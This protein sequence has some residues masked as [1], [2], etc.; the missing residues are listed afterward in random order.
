VAGEYLPHANWVPRTHAPIVPRDR[1]LSRVV[2]L[3][4][5]PDQS[6]ITLVGPPGAGKTTLALM[7]A[8]A[9]DHAFRDGVSF[10][11]L[12]ATRDPRLVAQAVATSIG[13]ADASG[14][15]LLETLVRVL[16]PR[17][18]LLILDNFEQV[19]PAAAT[20]R[21]L[22]ER[23]PQLKILVTSRTPLLLSFEQQ[24]LVPPMSVPDLR[25]PLVGD[26][27]ERSPAVALFKMRARAVDPEW[28]LTSADAAVVAEICV[29]LDG[30][31]LA[32][33][34]AASWIGIL[35]ASAILE[36]LKR[37][38][39]LLASRQQ[40]RSPRH[41]TLRAAI[42][43]SEDLLP[44]ELQPLFRSLGVFSGGWTFEAAAAICPDAETSSDQLLP[45][46]AQL[47]NHHLL[48]PQEPRGDQTCFHML[49]TIREYAL[50]RLE[51]SDELERMRRRHALYYLAL[52]RSA[53]LA[54]HGPEQSAWLDRLE[55]E[56]DNLRAALDWCA[57][58]QDAKLRE[59]GLEL[60]AGLWFFWTVRGHIREGRDRLENM[61]KGVG[62]EIRG[63]R[64]CQSAHGCRV[65]G[66]VQQRCLRARAAGG[67]AV[68]L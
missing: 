34:L 15:D 41:Q 44:T 56:Y 22:L 61:L 35:P 38:L 68:D 60:A 40:D 54:Y 12:S 67:G 55:N 43:W 37:M 6:L 28:E 47:V 65:A 5:Y 9:I 2:D 49:A 31:P 16:Q 50:E 63:G 14:E 39:D 18:K 48:V 29:R 53:E 25:L 21:Q 26:E 51:Q 13:I 64:T 4:Q 30:L 8:Q 36:R 57:A 11:D 42:R 58:E 3:V 32:I 52:V 20:V 10:V 33:E 1:E 23:C 7:A 46:I 62:A 17:N 45:G 19:L 66:L 59:L 27:I 24:C